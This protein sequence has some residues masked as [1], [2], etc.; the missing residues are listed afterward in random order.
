VEF[1][2]GVP[3]PRYYGTFPRVLGKYVREEGVLTLE[4]AVRKM[5]SAPADRL[6]LLDRGRI[7]EGMI[8]DL[9]L[10]NPDTIID[11]ATYERPHQYPLGIDTVIVNGQVVFAEGEWTGTRAGRV[12]YRQE[13]FRGERQ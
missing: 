2:E 6:G 9:T 7:K 1:G 11:R 10:F 3:H 13:S 5:T 4:E 12:I 8:A